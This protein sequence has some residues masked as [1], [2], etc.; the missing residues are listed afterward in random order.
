MRSAGGI[1][2]SGE[3]GPSV[4]TTVCGTGVCSSTGGNVWREGVGGGVS[5]ET[6]GTVSSGMGAGCR[7]SPAAG[8]SVSSV[9]GGNVSWA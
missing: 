9:E 5:K 4:P 6:G 3:T 7:V 1:V 8:G 2:G